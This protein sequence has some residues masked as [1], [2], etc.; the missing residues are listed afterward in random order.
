MMEGLD[1]L[2]Y[3]WDGEYIHTLWGPSVG[4]SEVTPAVPR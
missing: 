3:V 4:L 1:K 2:P